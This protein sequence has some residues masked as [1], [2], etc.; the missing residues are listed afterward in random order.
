MLNLKKSIVNKVVEEA[1]NKVELVLT[2]ELTLTLT[3]GWK[4]RPFYYLE[5][6]TS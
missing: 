3:M 4:A 1:I 6:E 2:K 5:R